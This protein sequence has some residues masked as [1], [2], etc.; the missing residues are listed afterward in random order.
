MTV[1]NDTLV[2]YGVK[3]MK[4]G[5]RRTQE[6]LDRA[7]GRRSSSS[8]SSRSNKR[9]GSPSSDHQKKVNLSSKATF[10]LSNKDLQ[11]LNTR[12][13]LEKNYKQ[14]T[15][16]PSDEVRKIAG[17]VLKEQGKRLA[18]QAIQYGSKKAA[19]YV[20]TQLRNRRK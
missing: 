8:S 2:H 10:E 12:L 18:N 7:A 6:Q 20:V 3:G 14:L 16:T 4:W 13:N 15:R 17:D 5:V 11:F 1:P 9:S 19:N